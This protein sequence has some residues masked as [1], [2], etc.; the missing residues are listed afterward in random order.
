MNKAGAAIPHC[1]YVGKQAIASKLAAVTKILINNI[2]FRPL[3]SPKRPKITPPNGRAKYPIAN[4][5][6]PCILAIAALVL[7]GK[8]AAAMISARYK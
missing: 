5:P 1:A 2:G 7:A 4:S 6:S 3:I 8:K